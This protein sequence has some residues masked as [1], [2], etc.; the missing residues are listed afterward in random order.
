MIK[1]WTDVRPLRA[2]SV[3]A[4]AAH[5]PVERWCSWQRLVANCSCALLGRPDARGEARWVEQPRS[6]TCFRWLLRNRPSSPA[7]ASE[8]FVAHP[9]Q[10]PS[11]RR[12]P[13]AAK[14]SAGPVPGLNPLVRTRRVETPAWSTAAATARSRPVRT[15]K[16]VRR[17]PLALRCSPRHSLLSA[18]LPQC[19]RCAC[20]PA[21]LSLYIYIYI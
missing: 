1:G 8:I 2:E 6:P 21:S 16:Q 9:Q 3:R 19:L 18:S 11:C 20:L 13:G 17:F 12:P 4:P 10:V 15:S 14:N 5:N 7:M